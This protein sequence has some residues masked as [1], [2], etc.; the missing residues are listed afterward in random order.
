M[1]PA[2][3]TASELQ[4]KGYKNIT[5][6][7]RK[8]T[9][10]G[11]TATSPE[12]Q[13]VSELKLP[14]IHFVTGKLWRKWNK[15]TYINA[16]QD[17]ILI[18]Y[19]LI[20]AALIILRNKPE[21]VIS[22]G[23]YVA[24][25]LVFWGKIFRAKVITHEQVLVPG[26]ANKLIAKFADKILISWEE[27]AKYFP[28][29]KI[30][31]TGNPSWTLYLK[32]RDKEEIDFKEN[33]PIV[34]IIGGNQ[35][36]K[37]VNTAVFAIL[38]ELLSFAN[39]IHQTGRSEITGDKYRA[40]EYKSTLKDNLAKRY[41][42]K[43]YIVD[44]IYE[45]FDKSELIIARGGANTMTDIIAKAKKCIIIPIPWSSGQEQLK[46]AQYLEKLGLGSIVQYKDEINPEQLLNHIKANLEKDISKNEDIKKVQTLIRYAP[47]KI[48][49]EIETILN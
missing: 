17:L 28:K 16:L 15:I 45:V 42:Y 13:M 35:G 49:K 37:V 2:Y 1:T 20:S 29:D 4:K 40:S 36:S 9:Q 5:W 34:S 14:F 19:G 41:V 33:L 47:S 32:S 39:V 23:G 22:F 31:L 25:P 10:R 7:G 26:L 44:N 43:T 21:L 3:I 46:N 48:I 38:D 12:Y 30:I 18:P 6:V 8:Y 24:L 27:S 11:D